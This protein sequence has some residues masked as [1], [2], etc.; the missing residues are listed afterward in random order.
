MNLNHLICILALLCAAATPSHAQ[1]RMISMGDTLPAI[2]YSTFVDAGILILDIETV[3]HE[4]PTCDYV[5]PSDLG[6]TVAAWGK[7]IINATRVPGRLRLTQGGATLFDSGDYIASRSGI[8]LRLRGN[9]SAYKEP[10]PYKIELQDKADLLMRN[11]PVY[12][13]KDWLLIRDISCNTFIGHIVSKL[14]GMTWT[15]EHEFVTLILNDTYQ[16]VYMLTE[17]VKRNTNC[18]INVSKQ[19]FL[20]ELDAYWWKYDFSVKSK[21]FTYMRY[22]VK[23]PDTLTDADKLFFTNLITLYEKSI[24]RGDY[25]RYID[26]DS[27]VRW[28]LAIDFLGMHDTAGINHYLTI[29][30]RN[31]LIGTPV[32]WDFGSMAQSKDEW[33]G[34]HRLIMNKFFSSPNNTFKREFVNRW[35]GITHHIIDDIKAAKEKYIKNKALIMERTFSFD[36]TRYNH[37]FGFISS[38]DSIMTY[39]EAR[40]AWIDSNIQAMYPT[41]DVNHD[42]ITDVE[43]VNIVLNMILG[44]IPRDYNRADMNK[45]NIIDV[46]DVNH[47]INAILK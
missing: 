23:Y 9:S 38:T 40:K 37:H 18:R 20:F 17:S 19:G 39:L 41:G 5:H 33:T 2:P 30:D 29:Y 11:N 13:D 35:L 46:T 4:M 44:I 16:G 22:D 21:L 15:P 6:I 24:D 42:W 31:S 25:Y 43:D 27:W 34:V 7:S 14:M 10:K 32:L 12:R 3:G 8:T 47:V 36:R 26:V 1:E 45:D 28:M